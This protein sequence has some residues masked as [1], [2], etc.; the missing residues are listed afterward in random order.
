MVQ[1]S[2]ATPTMRHS[3]NPRRSSRYNERKVITRA[4]SPVIPNTTRTSPIGPSASFVFPATVCS[5][6]LDLESLDVRLCR[7]AS[8]AEHGIHESRPVVELVVEVH[9]G[10]DEGEVAE[11]LR[12]IAELLPREPDLL[13]VEAE[14]VRVGQ[15]LLE[16]EL[17]FIEASGACERVDVPERAQREGALGAAEPV[18]R[19]TR[20]VAVDE[21]VGDELLVHLVER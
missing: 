1:S 3:S 14:V 12:E 17:G 5:L 9:G 13:G 11:C 4:R 21:A 19:C 20:V 2:T 16:R 10:V 18:G 15:H 8:L 6:M 7:A